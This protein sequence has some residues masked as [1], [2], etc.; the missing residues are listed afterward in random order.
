MRICQIPLSEDCVIS[1]FAFSLTV[2][3]G[4]CLATVSLTEHIVKY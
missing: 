4:N 2:Y 3:E 1:F